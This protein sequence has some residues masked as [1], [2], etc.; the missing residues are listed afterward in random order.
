[1]PR[2]LKKNST[3]SFFIWNKIK[4]VNMECCPTCNFSLMQTPENC[5]MLPC[6]ALLIRRFDIALALVLK[7]LI[8]L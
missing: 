2:S 8:Y 3:I 4:A 6:S 7:G 5:R 1:M